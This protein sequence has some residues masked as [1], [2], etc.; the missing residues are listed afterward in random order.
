MIL[1]CV[2]KCKY[3]WSWIIH[4]T[5]RYQKRKCVFGESANHVSRNKTFFDKVL[6]T[7]N[8]QNRSQSISISRISL[9]VISF[10]RR[11]NQK[12]C[13]GVVKL[14]YCNTALTM[15]NNREEISLRHC[16]FI[17]K[18]LYRL[19]AFCFSVKPDVSKNS[20]CLN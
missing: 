8:L 18:T 12:N 9:V 19:N 5:P 17:E 3:W 16:S 11:Y 4:H 7:K 2:H 10:C 1:I 20:L 6:K 14:P 15:K 13:H